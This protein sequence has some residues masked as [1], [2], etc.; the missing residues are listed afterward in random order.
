[1]E[2]LGRHET[3]GIK[4]IFVKCQVGSQFQGIIISCGDD[5]LVHRVEGFSL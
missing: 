4:H 5:S 2:R 1:M 3:N